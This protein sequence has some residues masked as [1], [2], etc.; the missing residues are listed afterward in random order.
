[1]T[2]WFHPQIS[3]AI[4]E[5]AV[6][7]S[8]V[9]RMLLR[10]LASMRMTSNIVKPLQD[11]NSD[12]LHIFAR[13]KQKHYHCFVCVVSEACSICINVV[14]LHIHVNSYGNLKHHSLIFACCS[15]K[16]GQYMLDYKPLIFYSSF[17][18]CLYSCLLP[19][20]GLK[21]ASWQKRD[22]LWIGTK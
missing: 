10:R 3:G 18:W 8:Y 21:L 19:G 15:S 7:S 20:M 1:M 13:H 6:V 4:D 17:F 12:S 22:F 14:N 5:C 16:V 9:F 2:P 11:P